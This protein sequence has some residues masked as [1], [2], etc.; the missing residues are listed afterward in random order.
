VPAQTFNILKTCLLLLPALLLSGCYVHLNEQAWPESTA[1]RYQIDRVLR[2]IVYTEPEWPEQLRADLYLPNR[3]GPLPVVLT[4]H[5]G[6]WANRD[7]GDMADISRELA[8]RGYAVLNLNY[9]FAPQYTY[10]AQ[11]LDLQQALGWINANASRYRLD[12]QRINAW[13]YSAGAHLAALL[14]GFDEAKLPRNA[15]RDLPR[16][17]AVVAG[18]IPADLRKYDNSPIIERFLGGTLGDIPER[19][20]EASPVYHVSAD[21]PAVFLYHGKFDF[22]VTP[23]QPR[24]YYDA[25]I[26]AGVE[27]EL[28]LHSFRGHGTMFL[29]GGDAESRAIDFLDRQ[30][31]GDSLAT[32]FGN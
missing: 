26:A 27:T 17:R 16:L 31:R 5:G 24:D 21:D 12:P 32:A 20:A 15:P 11:L 30:N 13:G 25:L 18:G 19:Y 14:G 1:N 22:L 10:P 23:D 6:G 28:Y 8:E 29:F 4:I 3:R 9:R 7:R 2:D